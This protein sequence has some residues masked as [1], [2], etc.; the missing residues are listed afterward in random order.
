MKNTF[1]IGVFSF[2]ICLPAQAQL[3]SKERLKNI[4]NFDNQRWSWGYYLGGNFYDFKFDYKDS[5]TG[6]D[7]K[8]LIVKVK[9][10]F[11]VGLI[12]NLRVNDYIDFRLEPGMAFVN[13][14]L[15][16]PEIRD[17]EDEEIYPERTNENKRDITSTY[18]HIPLL[19]KFSTK[20]INNFKPFVEAG[21]STSFNLSSNEK[22][23]SDNE[24]GEFRMKT[25]AFY[26]EIGFGIDFYLYF[27]KFTPSVRGVFALSNELKPDDNPDS[28]Y[29]GNIDKMSSRGL[30]IN[31]KFQ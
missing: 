19:V 7:L 17:A 23:N 8:D 1:L 24:D 14:T 10:G 31:L 12:G 5:G 30:F 6:K 11:N 18:I 28:P 15:V 27:F 20:R 16:F 29:T 26:Y 2:F 21:A 13:R 25:N 4:E 22:S 9:P 3:F